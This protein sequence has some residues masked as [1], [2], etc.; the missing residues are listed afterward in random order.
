MAPPVA[1]WPPTNLAHMSRALANHI[2]NLIAKT[3]FKSTPFATCRREQNPV[4]HGR[5]DTQTPIIVF[6]VPT[7]SILGNKNNIKHFSLQKPYQSL[8]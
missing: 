5:T 1:P 4:Y 8:P 7:N 3:A 2:Y 6:K